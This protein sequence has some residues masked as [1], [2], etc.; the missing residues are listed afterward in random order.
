MSGSQNRVIVASMALSRAD[1]ANPVRLLP[2]QPPFS[3]ALR[4][5]LL[6]INL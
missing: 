3:S 5:L 4:C 6:R 2:F 1:I